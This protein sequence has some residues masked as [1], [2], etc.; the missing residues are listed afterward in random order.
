MCR[1]PFLA[2]LFAVGFPACG[3][4]R[5]S[6]LEQELSAYKLRAEATRRND[7]E[8]EYRIERERS[9][10]LVAKITAARAERAR[11]DADREAHREAATAAAADVARS[12]A[13]EAANRK[14]LQ[15]LDSVRAAAAQSQGEIEALR[16][17]IV[18][19]EA[20]K[21][22]EQA[23]LAA[24]RKELAEMAAERERLEREKAGGG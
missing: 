4:S 5:L 24:I 15:E 9:E 20:Q 11:L 1:L 14:A 19:L 12:R 16:R 18:D 2:L 8:E 13:D 23:R 10:E 22:A 3:P 17:Q 6:L 7:L 21:K